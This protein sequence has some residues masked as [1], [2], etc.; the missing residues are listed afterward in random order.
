MWSGEKMPGV[1]IVEA[2]NTTKICPVTLL[3]KHVDRRKDARCHYYLSM[4]Y[5]E[6]MPDVTIAARFI[7]RRRR[8]RVAQ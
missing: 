7:Y 3:F 6:K 4:W 8:V 2:C 5:D 1:T